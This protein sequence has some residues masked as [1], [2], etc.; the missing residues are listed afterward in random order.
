MDFIIHDTLLWNAYIKEIKLNLMKLKK[1]DFIFIKMLEWLLK[2]NYAIYESFVDFLR[3][4][5]FFIQFEKKSFLW[6]LDIFTLDWSMD[7]NFCVF[8]S[9][10]FNTKFKLI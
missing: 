3:L 2:Y 7:E 1:I 5:N 9:I 6:K 10:K 4:R 8:L